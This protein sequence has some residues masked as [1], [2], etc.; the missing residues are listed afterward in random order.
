MI[1]GGVIL[2][3]L[4]FDVANPARAILGVSLVAVGLAMVVLGSRRPPRPVAATA[5]SA[6]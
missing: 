4:A 5:P 2:A 6:E 1:V 3:S